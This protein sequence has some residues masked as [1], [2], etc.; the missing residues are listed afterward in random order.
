MTKRD[1]FPAATIRTL[2]TE[3][4]TKAPIHGACALPAAGA[5]K[6]LVEIG[7]L[8]DGYGRIEDEPRHPDIAS[9]Q[10]WPLLRCAAPN[11]GA[12]SQGSLTEWAVPEP[13]D[14]N[15][16]QWALEGQGCIFPM[17]VGY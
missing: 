8:R 10:P 1:D 13:P 3:R 4:A 14:R 2:A 6:C 15:A 16:L 5:E 11:S 9:G 7:K 12:D 17:I